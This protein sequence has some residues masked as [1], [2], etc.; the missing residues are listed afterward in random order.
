MALLN[1]ECMLDLDSPMP[2]DA[3]DVDYDYSL[4][5]SIDYS[6]SFDIHSEGKRQLQTVRVLVNNLSSA[7][8]L[9]QIQL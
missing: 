2:Y 5:E 8:L 4:R 7:A 1:V 3:D 9:T 6:I